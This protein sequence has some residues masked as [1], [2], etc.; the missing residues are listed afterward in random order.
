M[1]ENEPLDALQCFRATERAATELKLPVWRVLEVLQAMSRHMEI[2]RMEVAA[3]KA[4]AAA[5][6]VP[7]RSE[8]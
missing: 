7:P 8:S 1:A 2:L 6:H 5:A 3:E 4:P